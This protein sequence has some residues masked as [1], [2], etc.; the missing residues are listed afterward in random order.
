MELEK[1]ADREHDAK[2]KETLLDLAQQYREIAE[3]SKNG[4]Y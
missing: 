2:I 4:P 3:Q 1:R